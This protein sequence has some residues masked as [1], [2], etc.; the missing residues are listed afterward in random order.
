MLEELTLSWTINA[1]DLAEVEQQLETG[2]RARGYSNFN[3]KVGYPQTKAYD[4]EL[5]RLVHDFAPDGFCWADANTAYDL[6]TALE[7]RPGWPMSAWMCWNR[8][9]RRC[10]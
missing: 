5:A 7:V 1:T 2:G 8:R 4:I 9:C 10:R 3:F 6:D